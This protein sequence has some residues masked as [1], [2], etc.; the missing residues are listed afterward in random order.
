MA[1]PMPEKP[2]TA[3]RVE[4]LVPCVRL[5]RREAVTTAGP[6]AT[7]PRSVLLL[8]GTSEAR[9]LAGL[10]DGR[11]DLRAITSLAGRVADPRA[12]PGEV[13]VGGFGGSAELATWISARGVE[14]VVDATHPFAG[15]ISANAAAACVA[16]GVPLVALRRPGWSAG[17][18]DDWHDAADLDDAAAQ[19]AGLGDRALLAIGRQEVAAFAEVDDAWFLIRA[20]EAPDGR[21]PRHHE[22]VLDRGPYALE[23]ERRLLAGHAIDLV[24]TKDSGGDATRAKLDAAR[25]RGIPVLVVRRPAAPTGPGIVVVGSAAGAGD[26]VHA[27]LDGRTRR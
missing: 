20:I 14:V 19:V 16:A 4:C 18:G 7:G 23:D 21:L 2:I 24:V 5:R 22:L 1:G 12:L 17:P 27:A 9:E 15:G 11:P 26:A 25:E 6:I 13:R 8:G 10:L 3:K